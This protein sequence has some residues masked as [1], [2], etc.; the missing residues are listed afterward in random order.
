MKTFMAQFYRRAANAKEIGPQSEFLGIT[1]D[2]RRKAETAAKAEAKRHGWRFIELCDDEEPAPL[3]AVQAGI[4]K[5]IG[6]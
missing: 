6:A 1:A 3:A 5:E 4:E 2:S